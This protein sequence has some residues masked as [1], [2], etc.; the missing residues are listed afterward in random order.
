VNTDQL[1][2]QLRAHVAGLTSPAAAVELLIAQRAWLHR[3]DFLE[4]FT[5]TGT[6]FDNET[7]STGIEWAAVINALDRDLACSGGEARLL[8][9]AASLAKGI[10]VDLRDAMTGLDHV[11]TALVARAVTQAAG[12]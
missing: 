1:H 10:P 4:R 2:Q 9:I 6:D 7:T 5:F 12:R 3:D 11:N 8:R